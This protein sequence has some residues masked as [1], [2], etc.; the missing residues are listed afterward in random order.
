MKKILEA[1]GY[2]DLSMEDYLADPCPRPSLSTSTIATIYESSALHAQTEHPR[3]KSKPVLLNENG[4][5]VEAEK[6]K[7]NPNADRG[8]A[9][10]AMIAGEKEKVIFAP[11][12]FQDWKKKDVQ[13]F[14][15]EAKAIGKIALLHKDRERVTR[16]VEAVHK[17]LKEKFGDGVYEKTMVWEDNGV[18][19]RGRTD[20]MTHSVDVD[21]KSVEVADARSWARTNIASNYLDIQAANRARGHEILFAPRKMYW[22]LIETNEPFQ[23]RLVCPSARMLEIAK[24]KIRY[25]QKVWAQALASGQYAGFDDSVFEADAPPYAELEFA[26]RTN[27]PEMVLGE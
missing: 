6:E 7:S 3:L 8:S 16:P 17:F 19:H 25:A 5:E 4:E 1:P 23:L 15:K 27:Q 22:L 12:E 9:I 2:Y 24:A 13:N 10:H 18:W 20:F 14:R 26:E 21:F 11:P